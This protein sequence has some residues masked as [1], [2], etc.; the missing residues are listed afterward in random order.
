MKRVLLGLILFFTFVTLETKSQE[1][2]TIEKSDD[3]IIIFNPGEE[4]SFHP[5]LALP[6]NLTSLR[7]T[8]D[9]LDKSF[10]IAT[11]HCAA[12][13]KSAYIF[14]RLRP[15]PGDIF[16]KPYNFRV[17]DEDNS[18]SVGNNFGIK[19]GT[20][21]RFFCAEETNQAADLYKKYNN[22]QWAKF[23]SQ[24]GVKKYEGNEFRLEVRETPEVKKRQLEKAVA[25]GK[26]VE[27]LKQVAALEE[28][29]RIDEKNL[30]Q[31]QIKL[32]EL[33]KNYGKKCFSKKSNINNYNECLFEQETK[34]AFEEKQ[35]SI[36]IANMSADDRRSYT[37]SEK[38]GFR[39]GSDKFK[40]CTFKIYQAEV[41]LEKLEL[42]KELLKANIELAKA[43]SQRQDNLALAQTEAAKMQ[44]LAARQQ[45]IAAETG[46]NLALLDL[47]M[48][49]LAPPSA[50]QINRTTCTFNGRFMNCF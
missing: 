40:D 10:N 30:K 33:E 13:D 23:Q 41:E 28:K 14:L 47:S 31:K 27:R 5:H 21:L 3:F 43:N 24:T 42:Q 38:F 4:L 18:A 19:I 36:K 9:A 25:K 26:E 7:K 50:P 22:I 20:K 44:A 15:H 37:C 49:L 29:R 39:K 17:F 35:I 1:Y 11:A 16:T 32:V 12:Q 6:P 45:A 34:A 46:K 48:K 8:T 2:N